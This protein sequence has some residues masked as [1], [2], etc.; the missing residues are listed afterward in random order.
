ML[1]CPSDENTTVGKAVFFNFIW[2]IEKFVLE[3]T[4]KITKSNHQPNL[5]SPTT[6]TW[7][8]QAEIQ[9]ISVYTILVMF[10]FYFHIYTSEKDWAFP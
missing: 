7:S 10:M 4:F 2:I 6:K 3:N 9:K 1:I 8:F 5:L